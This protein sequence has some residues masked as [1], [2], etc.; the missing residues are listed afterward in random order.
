MY[1]S[2]DQ[3]TEEPRMSAAGIPVLVFTR[4]TMKPEPA[5]IAIR[6]GGFSWVCLLSGLS[7]FIGALAALAVRASTS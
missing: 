5:S 2:F 4:K 6:Q 7:G 3:P 1:R